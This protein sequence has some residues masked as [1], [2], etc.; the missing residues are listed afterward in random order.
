MGRGPRVWAALGVAAVA[1]IAGSGAAAVSAA[2]RPIAVTGFQGSWNAPSLIDRSKDA[3]TTVG[4]DG[5]SLAASGR[6]V[7]RPDSADARQ[8]A[9]A[10]HDHLPA[11]LLV[12]N[13][14]DS[15]DDFSEPVGHAMLG[16]AA[17]R[18]AVAKALASDVRKQG[19]NGIS[20][21]L[22]SL[23]SRDRPG[24][25]AFVRTLRADL[26]S[27]SSLSICVMAETSPADY[28]AAGY[29]LRAIA[30]SVGRVILMTYDQHGTWENQPGPVGSLP[31]QR[32][33]LAAA[34]QDVPAGKLDLGIAEYGY[35]WRRHSNDQLSVAG[36][37]RL[38]GSRA[39]WVSWAGEWTAK[40]ADGS[41]LWWSDARSYRA[42]VALA[43][44]KGL[45]G[46]AVWDLG[47]GDPIR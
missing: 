39:R 25:T 36:A 31:W 30:A 41:T 8:L 33:T 44:A 32:S 37:R 24:L 21:D 20:V 5:V 17:H 22:E 6:T 38:A 46:V 16:N 42:R 2:P 10:H 29:D 43:R 9:R 26:P 7:G 23:T 14:S 34:R 27:G 11:E 1:A 4:V 18:S 13:F 40:L 15:I 19:W 47:L 12:S 45:H 28:T 3:L 35:A